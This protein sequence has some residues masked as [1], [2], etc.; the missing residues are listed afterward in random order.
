MSIR[1]FFFLF[2]SPPSSVCV[3]IR[4]SKREKEREREAIAIDP[5]DLD[6]AAAAAVEMMKDAP[7]PREMSNDEAA[8][9][10][11]RT[12]PLSAFSSIAAAGPS[13][14]S[15]NQS[16]RLTHSLLSSLL[17]SFVRFAF[18]PDFRCIGHASQR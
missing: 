14:S 11:R 9:E 13:T 7:F 4:W 12:E 1:F 17:S 16:D 8:A 6:W 18:T 5:L 3:I 10:R 15:S 2:F